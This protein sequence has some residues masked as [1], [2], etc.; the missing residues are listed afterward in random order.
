MAVNAQSNVVKLGLD[1][2]TM[3][4]LNLE[5][6]YAFTDNM[7]GNM[8]LGILFPQHLPYDLE[9]YAGYRVAEDRL[10]GISLNPTFRFYNKNHDAPEGFYT[11]LGFNYGR[12]KIKG[13]HN[14]EGSFTENVIH[15]SF[16]GAEAQ[17]GYQWI[18]ADLI[19]ID[20]GFIGIRLNRLGIEGASTC[21]DPGVVDYVEMKSDVDKAMDDVPLYGNNLELV[22]GQ[23]FMHAS[24]HAFF[25]YFTMNLSVGIKF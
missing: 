1:G 19:T 16:V 6:E 4:K 5:Y 7:S 11:G 17:F 10:S 18:I 9:Y 3:R 21:D 13:N 24:A 20:W 14:Y 15:V 2:L 12:Y 25:P 8:R 22:A 23:N